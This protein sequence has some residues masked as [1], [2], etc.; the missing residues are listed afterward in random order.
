MELRCC[1]E[2]GAAIGKLCFDASIEKIK[3]ISQHEDYGAHTNE[4]VL[5]DVAPLLHDKS[6]RAYRC[7]SG[8]SRNK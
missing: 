5:D 1:H 3:C 7:G 6:G 8:Q 4:S 2:V